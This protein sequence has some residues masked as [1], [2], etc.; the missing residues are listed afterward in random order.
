MSERTALELGDDLL[1][2]RV[3]A[4]GFVGVDD[5]QGGVG[6]ERVVAPGVEELPLPLGGGLSV[7]SPISDTV[8][9]STGGSQLSDTQAGPRFTAFDPLLNI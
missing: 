4:V 3:V 5:A 7:Y 8:R 1:D 9:P 2:D 6:D